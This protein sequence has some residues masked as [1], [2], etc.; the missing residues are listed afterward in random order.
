MEKVFAWK[1]GMN[2]DGESNYTMVIPMP[3]ED[4]V[5]DRSREHTDLFFSRYKMTDK[6]K[7]LFF[8]LI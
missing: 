7:N 4:F 2:N 5:F 6:I 3:Y 8:L 1:T